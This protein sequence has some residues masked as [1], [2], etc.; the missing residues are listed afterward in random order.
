MIVEKL[1]KTIGRLKSNRVLV[2]FLSS[3]FLSIPVSLA[4]SLVAL[5][6]I[7]PYFMGVW[8]AL[9]IIETYANVLRLGVVNGMNRELPYAL[10]SGRNEEAMSYARSTLGFSVL[11]SLL[12]VLVVP[13]VLMKAELNETYLAALLVVFIRTTLSFYITYLAGT[14]RTTDH[15]NKLS[16]IQ[17]IMLI[18]KLLLCPLIL[19][20]GFTGYLVMEVALALINGIMLHIFRPLRVKP[21]LDLRIIKLLMKTGVPLFLT[22]YLVTLID[23]FPRL[24]IV[25]FG[26]EIL[27]GLYAPVLMIISTFSLLPGTLGTFFYP[28]LTYLFGKN[29]D[30]REIWGKLVKI[31]LYASLLIIALIT[32][33]FFALDWVIGYFPKYATSLPYMKLSLLV[34]PFVLAKLGNLLNVVMK[35]VEYMGYYVGLY[36]LF[37]VIF[38]FVISML[39]EDIL[40]CAVLSQV[41]T[42]FSLFV[43][44][45]FM[46]RRAVMKFVPAD[47]A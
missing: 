33:A 13:F 32:A 41:L 5:R 37:Q 43:A 19:I 25:Y 22:S 4:V 17:F 44:S 42:T 34:G 12:L 46:N 30:A 8:S 36:A 3:T 40:V 26:D 10:G 6:Q 47:R 23:T 29:Q 35:K 16:N 28:R 15:F 21:D 2:K 20:Y 31:Y 45:Y 39:T 38:L 27:L 18:A 24:F 9:T 1:K 7:D 11:N 14:F